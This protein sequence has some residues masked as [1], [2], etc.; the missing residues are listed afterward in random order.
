MN[1]SRPRQAILVLVLALLLPLGTSHRG[2]AAPAS[3]SPESPEDASWFRPMPA[4]A[5]VAE[6]PPV[7][8][9]DAW[10]AA[11]RAHEGG[12]FAGA[13]AA[14]RQ[15]LRENPA[16]APWIRARLAEVLVATGE[17][18]AAIAEFEAAAS[19]ESFAVA[20]SSAKRLAEVRLIAGDAAGALAAYERIARRSTGDEQRKAQVGEASALA[21]IGRTAEAANLL[22]RVL[23]AGGSPQVSVLAADRLLALGEPSAAT[24]AQLA[25][26][27]YEAGHYPRAAALYERSI[28]AGIHGAGRA[29]ALM[30]LGRSYERGDEFR[31]AIGVYRR[32][33]AEH[34][35]FSPG[36]VRY[37]LGL[38]H[39]RVGEDLVGERWFQEVLD[40][41]PRS[42]FADDIL[43]RMAVRQDRK[44]ERAA[45]QALYRRLLAQYPRSP[46]A[47]EAAWKIG[48]GYF[49]DGDAAA[50]LEAFQAA[51]RRYP[52]SDYAPAMGYWRARILELRGD[53]EGARSSFLA[54]L[55]SGQDAYY[56]GRSAAA[57]RRL[58]QTFAAS[59][60]DAI[61]RH[62]EEGR[63][64][65]AIRALRVLRD[66][67]DAEVSE[68]AAFRIR[69][70]ARRIGPWG[71][72]DRFGDDALDEEALL[73]E[74]PRADRSILAA[75]RGLM[76]KGAWDDAAS[77]IVA[78]RSNGRGG[79]LAGEHPE[80]RFAYARILAEGGAYRAAMREVEGLVRG[81]GGPLDHASLP[82]AVA[83]LLYPG[84]Y[85]PIVRSEASRKG[86]DPRFVLSVIREESRFQADVASWAGAQ[87]LMQI[88]PATGA[89]VARS[90][91]VADFKFHML[92]DPRINVAFGTHYLAM[93]LQEYGGRHH[94][95]LAGYNAG[96][97][98]A[99]RWIRQNPGVDEDVFVER[100][101]F[102]ETR[103][104]VKKVLGT[105]W[106]YRQLEGEP[107][108]V[109]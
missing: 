86:V 61:D 24:S 48:F 67:G 27:Y 101:S 78:L 41:D 39:Q 109:L 59:D 82:P 45:A 87:G 52:R 55:R 28:E 93:L 75:I 1:M 108:G 49:E 77:E 51:L 35:E 100:I 42:S 68:R 53:L 70:L 23:R 63:I 40:R 96:P 6:M 98:N 99:N 32:I 15:A 30:Q 13:A 7:P 20:L 102:R 95:A 64:E 18:T 43:Y 89:G 33:L 34:P 90:L 26:L 21:A 106:T 97:G 12:Q 16:E 17:T 31:T 69:D 79:A 47:D 10:Q 73:A 60:W 74:I 56:R 83:R 29:A 71:E 19:A 84:Y 36:L 37:R 92:H 105:Y 4:L 38:C 22:H 50:A 94:L 65:D 8:R 80:H 14:Y 11:R 91:G 107:L 103:N 3:S 81:L 58:G 54:V 104:Y 88:M 9:E 44:E 72:L 62:V 46:W 76:A 57:L 2:P 66:A 85:G 25:E 5:Y